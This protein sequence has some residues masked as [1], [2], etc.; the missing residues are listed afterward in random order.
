MVERIIAWCLSNRLLV[1]IGCVALT[2]SGAWALR[3]TPIDALP[4]ISDVQVIISTEWAGRS[5]DLIENQV[6]YPLVAALVS[7]PKVKSVRGQTE[8]GVSNIFVIFEDGTDTDWARSRILEY[9]QRAKASLPEGV[10]P[11]MAPEATGVGWVF[12]YALVDR[13]G[14]GLDELR[15]LQDWTIRYNLASVPGV[16]EVASIG[17]FVK[18][19]Q[20][21]MDPS[22]LL[23]YHVSSK[24]VVDAIRSG[25]GDADGRLIEF[26][27]REY[28]VRTRGT[29]SSVDDIEQIGLGS[30]VRGTP[31]RVRDV[32]QVRVGPD[33]RRG[34]AELDGQGE[35]VGG[36][37]VMRSGE[38]ALDV[39]GRVK[40]RLNLIRRSL[41]SEVAIV[42]TYDRSEFIE[43]SIAGVRRALFEEMLVVALVV[44]AFLWNVRAALIPIITLPVAVASAFIPLWWMGSSVN[45]MS[46]GGIALAV[47]VLVDAAIV[48]VENGYRCAVER[49][50]ATV[51]DGGDDR[52]AA[53]L[54]ASRQVGRPMF[55]S[56]LIIVVSFTPVFLLEAQEGRLFHPLAVTKTVTMAAATVLALTLVPVLMMVLL[57]RRRSGPS[58]ASSNPVM[59]A[60]V[61]VYEPVL[62]AALHRRWTWLL[63]NAAIVP[64]VVPLFFA[65][66]HE[67]MPPFAEG[68]FLYMPTT[69]S[70]LS[71]TQTVNLVQKQDQLLRGIPE[72]SR[73][74]GT[75]GRATSATDN[76]PMSMVNTTILL[77]PSDQWRP[78]MT[79]DRLQGE[80]DDLLQL[81][82]FPSVW[83]QPI[84]SRI[85]MSSTGFKTPVG[86]KVLGP[87]ARVAADVSRRVEQILLTVSGTRSA[88]AERLDQGSYTDVRIDRDAVARYGL[89]VRDVEDVIQSSVGGDNVGTAI[90]GRERYPINV[91]YLRDF[92]SDLPALEHVLVQAPGGQ[93]VPLGQ[94][95]SVT[96]GN[97]AS[98]IRD[99]DGQLAAYVYVDPDTSDIGGYVDRARSAVERALTLPN[100]YRL[101]WS[102]QYEHQ[103]RAARR[104]RAIV[105]LVCCTIFFLLY[106]NF[107]SVSES[108]VVMASVVYAMTGGLM[109]QWCLGYNFSV[110]VWVGYI[111]L[112]GV[113]VQT[114][115]VMIVYLNE[116][117]DRRLRQVAGPLSEDDLLEAT[118]DGAVL[119]LR[120]KLMTVLTTVLGLLPILWSTGPA[121]G[122]MKPIAAPIVGGMLTSAVHVLIIT[123]IIFFLTKRNA[124]RR[125]RLAPSFR[126]PRVLGASGIT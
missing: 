75:A 17:G 20:V 117:L 9:L 115:V 121:S 28:M 123:P 42:P 1:A 95:A 4:D 34:M 92:R 70:G 22:R 103:L 45:V 102:G 108:A 37:V 41:P 19:Y 36:I 61:A 96:L 33:L 21:N 32:A 54:K 31:I 80:M 23:A 125:G 110:A 84:Q 71:L 116:M 72:V 59:R 43:R 101:Q 53:V 87:D 44:M 18:Q 51:D 7:A 8:F 122:L 40:E 81:P 29:L 11:I 113:A 10:A 76:S 82:G 24:Q 16:A 73:V 120:P 119:R 89:T 13:R 77:K 30:D 27:D 25:N 26:A 6:T 46:L 106:L 86:V 60:C 49:G 15:S 98:M 48:M 94:I 38:N 65:L 112:F 69:A 67:F 56:L 79:I 68:A 57:P 99:D 62:R 85:D 91:R 90:E 118:I 50:G 2:I 78:G 63:G 105:P 124:L 109:L 66:G 52:G 58:T 100:G 12:E 88:Y 47:G 107:K 3:H 55:F 126:A 35:V 104:L 14:L 74:F 5:P 39:V 93:Q 111:A 83:T 114:G 64:L 97:G